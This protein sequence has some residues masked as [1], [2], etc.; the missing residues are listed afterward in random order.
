[1]ASRKQLVKNRSELADVLNK[2]DGLRHGLSQKQARTALKHV[3]ILE[4]AL[5]AKGYKSAVM[6]LRRQAVK[7]AAALK[8]KAKK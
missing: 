2:L 3:E 7:K 8:K 6:V 1:M 5:I 4:T